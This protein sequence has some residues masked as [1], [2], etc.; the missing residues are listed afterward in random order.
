MLKHKLS[1]FP[2]INNLLFSQ[3]VKI[4]T[5]G[6]ILFFLFVFILHSFFLHLCPIFIGNIDI[7][8][9]FI[10]I[11][12][13]LTLILRLRES[14]WHSLFAISSH[15]LY[16]YLRFLFIFEINGAYFM[17][18]CQTLMKS[19]LVGDEVLILSKDKDKNKY[20]FLL[21]SDKFI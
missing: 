2:H 18:L 16:L 21:N 4:I 12:N 3:I 9:I 15:F 7:I 11:G 13:I 20:A 1:I 17:I 5:F 14:L 10:E 6:H 8:G 19:I